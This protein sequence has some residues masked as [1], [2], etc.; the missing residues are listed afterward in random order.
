MNRIFTFCVSVLAVSAA[1]AH[2]PQVQITVDNDQITTRGVLINDYSP[3]TL[4]TSA[5][6]MPALLVEDLDFGPSWRASATTNSS[7]PFGPG[8]AY[9]LGAGFTS[10]T[11][12]S[13]S[14][15]EELMIWD[16]GSFV[17]A[18]STELA[19]VRSSNP[20]ADSLTGNVGI[21]GT[22]DPSA[23]VTIGADYTAN[24]HASV[25]YVLLGDGVDPMSAVGDGIYRATLQLS[26]NEVGL[27]SSE[28]FH[29]LLSK[30]SHE[31]IADAV[32]SLG[33]ATDAVQFLVIPEPTTGLLAG[34]ATIV[35]VCRR[36]RQ[37]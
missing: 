17:S 11:E 31:G 5:Y 29:L 19:A 32:A 10:G 20:N 37:R 18:G 23:E 2:G 34:F 12:L 15:L 24:A 33:L 35:F 27:A 21:S 6:A 30:G 16:G 1:M 28:P 8:V 36:D 7:Y 3:L 13:L 9:G 22:A 14:F 25:T 26:S 4:E